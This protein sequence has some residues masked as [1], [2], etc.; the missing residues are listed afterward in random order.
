MHEAISRDLMDFRALHRD[1]FRDFRQIANVYPADEASSQNKR[2]A[3]KGLGPAQRRQLQVRR[4]SHHLLGP[5]IDL[6][7]FWRA[8]ETRGN[9]FMNQEW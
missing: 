9:R 8:H 5:K 4:L 7:D 2:R 6:H 1:S 3:Q